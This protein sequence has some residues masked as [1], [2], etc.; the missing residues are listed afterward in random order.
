MNY[1]SFQKFSIFK[2]ILDRNLRK[3]LTLYLSFQVPAVAFPLPTLIPHLVENFQWLSHF[4]LYDPMDCSMPGFPILHYPQEF[5]QI[6]INMYTYIHAHMLSHFTKTWH[7]QFLVSVHHF[8]TFPD[9]LIF[10]LSEA[11]DFPTFLPICQS[12][13]VFLLLLHSQQ[14]CQCDSFQFAI[15]CYYRQF[16]I[17][18]SLLAHKKRCW[19]NSTIHQLSRDNKV[20]V[21][22][23]HYLSFLVFVLYC[24][25]YLNLRSKCP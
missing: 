4:G 10:S 7:A 9:W 5:A 15:I 3:T 2:Q 8:S 19:K 25:F 11:K 18:Y 22:S 12:C 21:S 16:G 17:L 14:W 23:F 6:Y 13:F 24:S 20:R 1:I